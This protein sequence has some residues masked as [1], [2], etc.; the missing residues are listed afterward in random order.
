MPAT[1]TI[2][3]KVAGRRRPLFDD[4]AVPLP[5]D[6]EQ[7]LT[8]RDLIARV[9]RAEVA[10]FQE[11]RER[12]RLVQ[13]LTR[14]EVER[15]AA[16]GKVDTGGREEAE[17]DADPEAAV[18]AALQAFEDGLYYVF[19]DGEQVEALERPVAVRA[20]S[21]VTFLRLVALAGG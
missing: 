3:G 2:E 5:E 14:E 4:W 16:R 20:E 17:P 1:I 18:A 8:L 19:I 9:V 13:A 15:G 21:R 6:A 10:A 12:R 7:G 11:R